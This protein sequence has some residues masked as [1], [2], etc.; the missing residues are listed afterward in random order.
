[1]IDQFEEVFT[2]QAAADAHDFLDALAVAVE[3]P[4]SPLRLITTLRA[5]YYHRPLEHPTFAPILRAGSIDVLPLAADELERAIVEPARALG[6]SFEPGLVARIAAETVGQPSPLPLLQYTLSELFERR[7]LDGDASADIVTIAAYDELGGLAGALSARA[8]SIYDDASPSQR[9]AIRTVF[10]RM[11]NPGEDTTD[12]R[13]RVGVADLANSADTEWVLDRLGAA[14]LVT[15]DRDVSTREPTVEVAH[16]ALLRQ[17]PRLAGWLDE[18]RDVLRSAA[19]IAA[20]AHDLG[21]RR[22]RRGLTCTAAAGSTA[23]SISPSARQ[24]VSAHSICISS[25]LPARLQRRTVTSR[26]DG[27]GDFGGS[28][29]VW[30]PRSWS[31]SSPEA[32]L[33]ASSNEPTIRHRWRSPP[34]PKQRSPH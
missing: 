9:A 5:D 16:E 29:R 30:L 24:T 12:L 33:S 31:P 18:D 21:S 22:A 2:G 11:T 34:Q 23:R 28:S 32:L 15:F 13:Q 3:D 7:T 8:E 4:T 27:S 1:M 19:L 10:G 14:R 6:V 17:W 20:A 26:L 25:K